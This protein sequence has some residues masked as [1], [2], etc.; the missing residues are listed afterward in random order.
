MA[1][2]HELFLV[3][4]VLLLSSCLLEADNTGCGV[5]DRLAGLLLGSI[6]S[7]IGRSHDVNLVRVKDEDLD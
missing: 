7:D 1:N 3:A 6:E 5:H 2:E 4:L